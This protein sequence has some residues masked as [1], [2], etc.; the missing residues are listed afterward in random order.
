MLHRPVVTVEVVEVS[1][2]AS[3]VEEG[4]VDVAAEE[5]VVVVVAES[6]RRRK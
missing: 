3:A 2:A 1:E 5:A 4:D 6:Q